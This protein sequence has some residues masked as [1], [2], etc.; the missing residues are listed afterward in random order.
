VFNGW[1]EDGTSGSP[2]GYPMPPARNGT[3]RR[4]MTEAFPEEW[5]R[6]LCAWA[7]ANPYIREL[8]LFG[9]RADETAR[10]DSDV[11]IG[12]GLVPPEG[13][14]NPALGAF[15][16]ESRKWRSQLEDIVGHHVS[17]EPIT[18]DEP[19]TARVRK[20]VLIW[21]RTAVDPIKD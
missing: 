11:D 13:N 12:L 18:P 9:S 2:V 10:P 4:D 3:G 19:G 15:L 14:N 6:R 7:T 17:L 5:R 1:R 8:W 20:W 21:R 16:A